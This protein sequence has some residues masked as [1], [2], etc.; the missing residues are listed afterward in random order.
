MTTYQNATIVRERVI[1]LDNGELHLRLLRG[2]AGDAGR[3]CI[4]RVTTDEAGRLRSD[5]AYLYDPTVPEATVQA[6]FDLLAGKGFVSVGML[7]YTESMLNR[8]ARQSR[9]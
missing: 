9:R 4:H 6:D 5:I 7:H 8:G 2:E 1:A 3:H